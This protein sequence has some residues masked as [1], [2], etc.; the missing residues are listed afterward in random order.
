MRG[1]QI[2]SKRVAFLDRDGVINEL[3]FFEESEVIDSPL[4]PDQFKLK[5]NAAEGIRLLNEA[6]IKAVV[7]SNQPGMAKGKMDVATHKAISEKMHS[8]LSKAG[9]R[10]DGEYYCF[11]HP[12]AVVETYKVICDCRKPKPGLILKAAKEVGADLKDSWMVGDNLSDI[13]AGK[14]AGCR[15]ILIGDMK[16]ELCSHMKTRG[17]EPDAIASS[18]VEAAKTIIGM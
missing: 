17:I 3:V 15:T 16:C 4:T 12:D 9:A 14:R 18:L 1:D 2:T 6:G 5:K 13:E 7:I 10:L 8:Q 11:H